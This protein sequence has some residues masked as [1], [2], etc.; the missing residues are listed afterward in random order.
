LLTQL[1]QAALPGCDHELTTLSGG[2]VHF[3]RKV[4]PATQSEGNAYVQLCDMAVGRDVEVRRSR[5]RVEAW[6]KGLGDEAFV[7]SVDED[8]HP[9]RQA[10]HVIRLTAG[11]S[12]KGRT[13]QGGS[14]PI[15]ADTRIR[16]IE[17]HGSVGDI[18]IAGI[19]HPRPY[20]GG[21]TGDRR[22]GWPVWVISWNYSNIWTRPPRIAISYFKLN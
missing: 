15:D 16:P 20:E 19:G 9:W 1:A 14:R 11:E 7:S 18:G 21:A 3:E 4:K 13:D 5:Q 17:P 2:V 12:D 8:R 22:A 10:E 6:V